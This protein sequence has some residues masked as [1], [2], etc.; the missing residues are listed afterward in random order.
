MTGLLTLILGSLGVGDVA[1]GLISTVLRH[2]AVA[3]FGGE[4]A[5]QRRRQRRIDDLQKFIAANTTKPT[6]EESRT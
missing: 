3:G 6:A 2:F 4:K 5:K 1:A